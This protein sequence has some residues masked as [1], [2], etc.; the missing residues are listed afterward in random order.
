MK[1]SRPENKHWDGVWL[2]DNGVETVVG[3]RVCKTSNKSF[4]S[5]NKIN[6]VCSVTINPHTD[7]RA[8]TFVEDESV[9]DV[10]KCKEVT[11]NA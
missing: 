5:G 6:T 10:W 7:R 4:K 9:V 2:I 8:F 1:R 11:E 3:K